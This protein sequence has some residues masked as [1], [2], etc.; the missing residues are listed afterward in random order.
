M[1]AGW[2]GSVV[3]VVVGVIIVIVGVMRQL[4]ELWAT[5]GHGRH[6]CYGHVHD[7]HCRRPRCHNMADMQSRMATQEPVE[8]LTCELVRC[9]PTRPWQM[10][11]MMQ[12]RPRHGGHVSALVVDVVDAIS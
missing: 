8:M 2:R 12:A 5:H 1:R 4:C 3:I 11:M 9:M 6:F 10:A 7:R